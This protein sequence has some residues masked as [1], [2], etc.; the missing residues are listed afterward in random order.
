MKDTEKLQKLLQLKNYETPGDEY[1]ENFLGEFKQRQR[2]EAL[3]QSTFGLLKER[4]EDWYRDLGAIKWVVPAGSCAALL[5]GFFALGGNPL[6][7]NEP[8]S[9][10]LEKNGSASRFF[11]LRIPRNEG[12]TIADPS[13]M[14]QSPVMPTNFGGD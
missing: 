9:A 11:E 8:A 10:N 1:F 4:F 12:D 5:A 3:K 14:P 6:T 7:E 13:V 2:E